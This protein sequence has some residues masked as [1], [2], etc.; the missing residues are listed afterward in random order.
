MT[1]ITSASVSLAKA[2]H[3]RYI[4]KNLALARKEGWPFPSAPGVSLVRVSASLYLTVVGW[5][6]ALTE[7]P[8]MC[9]HVRVLGCAASADLDT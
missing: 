6:M 9:F 8:T 2:S 3:I 4:V 7:R 5:E 1:H